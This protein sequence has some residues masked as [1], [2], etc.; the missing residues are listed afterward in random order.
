MAS[1]NGLQNNSLVVNTIDGLQTIYAT[2][3]YDNGVLLQP[4]S[5]VPY[6]GAT[7]GVNLGGQELQTS[8]VPT[9]GSDVVNL[10]ALQ[11][12]ILYVEGIATANFVPYTGATTDT[13]L[14]S[15]NIKTTH[16]PTVGAD[17]T[18]KTYVDGAISTAG[19]AFVPYTG[20][21]TNVTLGTHTLTTAGLT[22]TGSASIAGTVTLTGIASGTPAVTLGLNSSNQIIS[23]AD[24]VAPI[25]G[26][27]SATKIPYAS[28]ANVLADSILSQSGSTVTVTGN[29]TVTGD[30]VLSGVTT[31]SATY[32]LGVNGSNKVVQYSI[33]P[34][35]GSVSAGYYPYASSAN[36]LANSYL[37]QG[38]NFASFFQTTSGASNPP[39]STTNTVTVNGA[40]YYTGAYLGSGLA[41]VGQ[42]ASTNK[43]YITMAGAS[44]T[45]TQNYYGHTGTGNFPDAQILVSN[46]TANTTSSNTGQMVINAG[47]L[48]LP[49]TTITT[50]GNAVTPFIISHSGSYINQCL[51]TSSSSDTTLSLANSGTGGH[52]WNLGSGSG[53]SG[54]GN[55]SFYI[56]DYTASSVRFVIDKN[57]NV[58]IGV[59][60]PDWPLSVKGVFEIIDVSTSQ[61]YAMYS[62]SNVLQINPRTS[63]GGYSTSGISI[64]SSGNVGVG[65]T[66]Q[67]HILQ[68]LQNIPIPS[69][70]TTQD[71]PC[72]LALQSN[73]AWLKMGQFYTSGVGAPA[74]IQSS[75]YYS[76]A[77]HPQPLLIQPLGGY[78][79]IGVTSPYTFLHISGSSAGKIASLISNINT[80]VSSSACLQFGL[81]PSSG[82]GTSS[83]AGEIAAICQNASNGNTD[84]AFSVFTG[85]SVSPNYTLVERMRI[86]ANGNIGLGTS[87]PKYF[88]DV[89]WNGAG[90]L[91]ST[92][93][94][95]VVASFTRSISYFSTDRT[96]IEVGSSN[97]AAGNYGNIYKYRMGASYHGGNADFQINA[98]Q[99]NA[100][101]YTGADTVLPRLTI[102]SAGNCGIGTT[103]PTQVLDVNGSVNAAG[104][105]ATTSTNQFYTG[106]GGFSVDSRFS[107]GGRNSIWNSTSAV[108]AGGMSSW[109]ASGYTLF[110]NTYAPTNTQ[111]AL[112][113]GCNNSTSSGSAINYIVNLS[114]NLFWATLYTMCNSAYWYYGS[115]LM[116]YVYSGGFV[117]VSDEREKTDIAD[118]K[119]NRSLEKVLA[120]KPK[121]YKRKYYDHEVDKDGNATPIPQEEKDKIHIGLVAQ[122][123]QAF[124]P[125]CVTE[126]SNADNR[127]P[128]AEDDQQRLGIQYNDWVIHLIGAVQ[129]QQ[130][131]ITEQATQLTEQASQISAL[132]SQ[133]NTLANSFQQ[134]IQAVHGTSASAPAQ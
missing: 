54:G 17:L 96:D 89:Q 109:N 113:L 43:N 60:S 88:L 108:S 103:A 94:N 28:S 24:Y 124:N 120:C 38:S 95:T 131:V 126:W 80:A 78:V 81:W 73:S 49:P 70:T 112:A 115:T 57:G 15:K 132:Q 130:K 59:A 86:T 84:M 67:T 76:G 90:Y 102:D 37:F 50:A 58:G 104:Y 22:D 93:P 20:A 111:F 74:F 39:T 45:L 134:Y 42:D 125:H 26:S 52:T 61:K 23:F 13:D 47:S 118:L 18:N 25:G 97:T 117:S 65:L 71:F 114:P 32:G 133:I 53:S 12:A 14:G 87:T 122:D 101:S 33:T 41:S 16:V 75:D 64:N 107:Y 110:C 6:S 83:P 69:F 3:I 121:Y 128:T 2:S 66:A 8:Y 21:T 35:T 34:Y 129:E 62:D 7:Q 56:F 63:S 27:V 51:I 92:A 30:L 11:N 55:G 77:E 79:G 1:T 5:Y 72:Q 19:S 46:T 48:A 31:A 106:N 91:A 99:C 98:V 9:V 40:I 10:T 68:V 127:P 44:G 100:S 123:V 82:S 119:T 85:T 29:E 105:I 4:G 116:G 36:V